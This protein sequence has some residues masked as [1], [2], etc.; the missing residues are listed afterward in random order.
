[1]VPGR[2]TLLAGFATSALPCGLALF[3]PGRGTLFAG[4]APALFAAG[5]AAPP[6]FAGGSYGAP[7]SLAATTPRPLNDAGRCVA[8]IAGRPWFTEALSSRFPR[9]V[10][11]WRVCSVVALK[12]FSRAARC[13]TTV[14]RASIPPLP[15]L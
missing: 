1:L 11:S 8:A 2:G 9:A 3:A 10:V 4:R 13:S 5:F 7:A 6:R 14:G 15:P 12:C